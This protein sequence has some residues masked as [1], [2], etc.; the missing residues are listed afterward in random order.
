MRCGV[1]KNF[2]WHR[3]QRPIRIGYETHHPACPRLGGFGTDL[4]PTYHLQGAAFGEEDAD[5]LHASPA[6]QKF[7]LAG[8]VFA[9]LGA[10]FLGAS[11]GI[12]TIAGV[13]GAAAVFFGLKK[14][15]SRGPSA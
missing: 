5:F 3:G 1:C 12:A 2:A 11:F 4:S 13:G 8:G 15:A 10:Y 6:D 9:G 7:S 14:L